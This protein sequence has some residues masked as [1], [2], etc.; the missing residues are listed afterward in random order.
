MNHRL[1]AEEIFHAAR[2]KP[3]PAERAGFLDGACG[4]DLSLRT[5]VEA[6]LKADAEAGEFLRSAEKAP[7]F[8]A[9]SEATLAETPRDQVGDMVGR[10]KLLQQIGEGGFGVVYMAEQREPVK[11]R[12]ALKIIKLGMDTRQVIARFEAERQALAMMDHPHIAR[13]LDAGSTETGRL[14]F[15]ME[16]IKGVPI[17]EYCDT[18]KLDIGARLELFTRVCHAIQHAHQKGIIH[19]DIKPGNVLVTMHDGVPVPKVI[20]FG[21]AKATSAE[22]TVK[23]LFTEH[24]QMIGTAAYMSP[25]QA[26]MSGLDIDTRSDIYALGV[27]LYEL[28][29]GTTPFTHEELMSKGFAEIMRIIREVEPHKPST[30]LSSLGDTGTR[31][32]LQRRAVDPK[33]L[34]HALRGDL[35]WIIMKCLEKDR[36]RRYETANGLAMDIRRY[37]GGEAV[38]AAPP[39][40]A[41]RLRKFVRRHRVLVT[42]GSAVAAAL[43]IGVIAFAWQA[44]VARAQRDSAVQ[45]RKTAQD[46]Q[47]EAV[48]QQQKAEAERHRA[49]VQLTRA[50][51]LVYAGRLMLAQTDFEAGNGGLALHY[52]GECQRNLRGW[53]WRYL[54][55]RINA[56]GTL[57][58]HRGAV[59]GVAISPDGQRIVTGSEDKTAKVWDATTG[60][61]LLTL[62]GHK[63]LV[64]GVAFSPDGQ[65]IVTGGG[66]WGEG[67]HPGEV[68]VWDAATGQFLHDLPGHTYCVWS[69]AFSPDGQRIVTG[70]G[71]WAYGPGE[72]KVWDA[73]TGQEV[74]TLTGHELG[75]RS[76]TFSPDGHR[77]ATGSEDHTARVWDAATGRVLHVLEHTNAVSSVAFSPDGR[78]IVT[79]IREW[80]RPGRKP[81]E[82]KV[83][84]AVTG[85]ELFVL[86]GHT[87]ALLSVVFS[88]DGKRIVTASADQTTRVW[89]AATGQELLVLK[90]HAGNVRSVTFGPDG[91]RI[92]TAS[93]DRTAKVWDAEKGQEVPT[94]N[95]HTDFVSSIAFSPDGKRIVTGSGDGTAKVWD[96]ATG[97]G[98]L[99][100][101]GSTSRAWAVGGI[102]SVAFSPDGKRIVTGGG[103]RTA[104]VWDATTG[105]VLH[106]LEHANVV[107][108]VAFSP[109]G[110][111][112][113]TGSGEW[114][115]AE[116][117]PGEVKVWDAATGQELLALKHANVVSTVA[118]SPDG[119]RIVTGG[120]DRTA[121]VWDATTGREVLSL[122]GHTGALHSVAFS[123]DGKRI[124]TGSQDT[125]AKVWDAATGQELL[126]LEGHTDAVRS[127]T[128]IPDG[129]RIVTGSDD[130]SAKV[131]DAGTGQELLALKGHAAAVW[132]VASGPDG[133]RIVT[134][135][136]GAHAIAKVWY[137]APMP[138]D[139]NFDFG[140][141]AGRAWEGCRAPARVP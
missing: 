136:A 59:S 11:R 96:T 97:R 52:L 121:K 82:A 65:R 109:D 41:Y 31:T 7:Q 125:T 91:K 63:G 17:L 54:W 58:G 84:D 42:A 71:D 24:R 137:A 44:K 106:V 15:V 66:P 111:R 16:Y 105:R 115:G 61:E 75:V 60:Q 35:D 76:V 34:S 72:V 113:V 108:S 19:R 74:F 39:S 67:K 119:K 118:F 33:K 37:L 2:A 47:A 32:A 141:R 129:N 110:L 25:E 55:T 131:W 99:T 95:G 92:V 56:K 123:P 124:I 8:S 116:K 81:G 21:I 13:V 3:D 64:L 50:E 49:E 90:G 4:N 79:G 73:V 132:S 86:E 30:R 70:A 48:A 80:G 104:K 1:T 12:V 53:E 101:E 46:A 103:D 62:T 117:K 28:L 127:V 18:E 98:V 57:V 68:K 10:Y 23:T 9:S 45:A 120:G 77:I 27:L 40:A 5:K 89:D 14:Y 51:G 69:V 87:S 83:W 133:Q 22:L 140:E 26:E 100:L 139:R 126:T 29:T 93:N 36:T 128:F 94:L 78:R 107:R 88:P 102:W 135:I 114:G 138:A 130:R 20:D 38:V 43:L 134:G 6:L 85:Q 122:Q 112:I